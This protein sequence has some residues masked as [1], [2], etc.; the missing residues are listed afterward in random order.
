MENRKGSHW[1]H[2]RA[3]GRVRVMAIVD[4]DFKDPTRSSAY[5]LAFPVDP[6][7]GC[8]K[9]DKNGSFFLSVW[10]LWHFL[11]HQSPA[12]SLPQA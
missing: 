6:G 7:D 3:I 10:S 8:S 9:K 11:P 2:L 12:P 1:E 5:L 4:A